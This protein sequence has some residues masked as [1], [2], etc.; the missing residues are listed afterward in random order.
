MNSYIV[1]VSISFF[2]TIIELLNK[3]K[4]KKIF[5]PIILSFYFFIFNNKNADYSSYS[6]FFD[7]IPEN[8][9]KIEV[10]LY[11]LML[12][13]KKFNFSYQSIPI[14]IGIFYFYIYFFKNKKHLNYPSLIILNYSIYNLIFDINQIRNLL[15]IIFI[16]IG[17]QRYNQ[18]LKLSWFPNLVAI[19]FHK[20]GIVY[21]IFGYLKS[22]SMKK[23]IKIVILGFLFNVLFLQIVKGVTLYFFPDKMQVYYSLKV[24]FGGLLYFI[25][26]LNDLFLIYYIEGF[27]NKKNT[28]DELYLKFFMFIILF[29]PYS[30]LSLEIMTRLYRNVFLVKCIFITNKMK[31]LN[32]KNR[33]LA[34]IIL[35]FNSAL[36]L[37]IGYYS[38]PEYTMSILKSL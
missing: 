16:F 38:S 25:I 33:I 36:P 9:G 13:F 5:I 35:V 30:F 28:L 31:K 24:N 3:K 4:E 21:L 23:Y 19:L 15:M 1:L 7:K 32:F 14:S 37:I 22:F 12:F 26:I 8:Y 17:I 11:Y 29:L 34:A 10:G 20:F 2:C 18:K 27:D 6:L